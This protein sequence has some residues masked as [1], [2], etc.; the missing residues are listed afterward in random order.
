MIDQRY[1]VERL[2]GRGGMADVYRAV[3]TEGGRPVAV[4]LLRDVQG[5]DLRRF[6]IEAAA[7][8][9]L[10]HPGVVKLYRTGSH[11]G[12]P[13]LALELVDGPTLAHELLDG[14]LGVERSV[15]VARELADAIAHA[16]HVPVVHR[17][18]KPGNVLFD[19]AG[20]A[21]LTDFGIA[22][23][24]DVGAVTATGMVVGTAA[25]VAPEQLEERPVG[26]PADIYALGLVVLECLTGTRCYPGGQLE[27]AMAR[28]SRPAA[29]PPGLPGW[30]REVLAAMTARDPA[31]RPTAG[32]AAEA[33]GARSAHS[34]LGATARIA[35]AIT[36]TEV[37]APTAR[38]ALHGARTMPAPARPTGGRRPVA[39]RR[40]RLAAVAAVSVALTVP[41]WLFAGSKPQSADAPPGPDPAPAAPSATSVS[42]TAPTPAVEQRNA[43]AQAD[44]QGNGRHGDHTDDGNNRGP[45]K[46]GRG[47][48]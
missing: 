25:Y 44:G 11:E 33:F 48:G 37:L 3:D 24:A 13:Y 27:A 42:S 12:F 39:A 18:V 2:L 34:V 26:P 30:L 1:R 20:R 22:R 5:Q 9:S 41:A 36:D 31:Q 21:R 35:C 4:K 6:R 47:K 38:L 46:S 29:I 19:V 23:V 17:D 28:L 45:G 16:H 32:A 14:P 43:D 15:D 40:S 7:L 10:D 8:A